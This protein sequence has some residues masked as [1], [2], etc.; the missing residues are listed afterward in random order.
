M[1]RDTHAYH[2]A[3]ETRTHNETRKRSRAPPTLSFS[4]RYGTDTFFHAQGR[5]DGNHYLEARAV[6]TV[7]AMLGATK[8]FPHCCRVYRCSISV[9]WNACVDNWKIDAPR[10]RHLAVF[11]HITVIDNGKAM[12]RL[13]AD[14]ILISRIV[15]PLKIRT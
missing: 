10:S 5:T 14:N 15:V 8:T 7:I 1:R 6:C 13:Y 12:R 4:D 2:I 11:I 3:N 9:M